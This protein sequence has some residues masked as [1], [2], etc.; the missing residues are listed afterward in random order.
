MSFEDMTEYTTIT[1][2]DDD[3]DEGL[4]VNLNTI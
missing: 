4:V 3:V 1:A 2:I